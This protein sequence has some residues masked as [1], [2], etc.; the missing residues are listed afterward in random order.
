MSTPTQD[1]TQTFFQVVVTFVMYVLGKMGIHGWS[2]AANAAVCFYT[3]HLV[4]GW[5]WKAFWRGLLERRGWLQPKPPAKVE[6]D[7]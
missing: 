4:A 2:E 7:E 1:P 3:L 6:E 5:W